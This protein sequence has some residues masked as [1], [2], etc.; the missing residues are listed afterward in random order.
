MRI[1]YKH[2]P[3][4]EQFT[5]S[6]ESSLDKLSILDLAIIL[7][8]TKCSKSK[9]AMKNEIKEKMRKGLL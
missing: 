3:T 5:L 4:K 8:G 7:V 2:K 1:F 6:S 9:E